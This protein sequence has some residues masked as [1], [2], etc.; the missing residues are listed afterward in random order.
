[1]ADT[2][3]KPPQPEAVIVIGTPSGGFSPDEFNET[4]S[5]IERA[6]RFPYNSKLLLAR[7]SCQGSS[8][9]HNQNN[10]VKAARELS[11]SLV[12][13]GLPPVDAILFVEN[14]ESFRNAEEVVQ[15]LWDHDKD[16]VGATYAFKFPDRIRAMGV[17][18]D[19][20][21]IDWLSLYAREPLTKVLALPIG[22][23]MVK[24]RVFDAMDAQ[25][26]NTVDEKGGEGQSPGMPPF[27]HDVHYGLRVVRTTDYVFCCRAKELGF[28]VWLDA[29][30]SLEIDHWGKFP[31]SFPHPAKINR[32][33][34]SLQTWA[35]ALEQSSEDKNADPELRA[36]HK[37]MAQDFYAVAADMVRRR[38]VFAFDPGKPRE[39]ESAA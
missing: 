33:I 22:A 14:D 2:E 26:V 5:R 8:I 9:A 30:L 3:R 4:M 36:A 25:Q 12:K 21:N 11:E 1:M 28:D 18:A 17:E 20:K 10:I 29:P 7:V 19:G 27:Y 32:Q 15:R 13:D 34:A 38:G 16:I 35:D 23:L 39:E 6:H 24:M 37:A 31:F